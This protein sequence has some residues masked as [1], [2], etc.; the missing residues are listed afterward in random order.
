VVGLWGE[1]GPGIQTGVSTLIGGTLNLVSQPGRPARDWE[2]YLAH[3]DVAT[4]RRTAGIDVDLM[5]ATFADGGKVDLRV[6]W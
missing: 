1:R 6:R 4:G 2:D 5:L 3:G